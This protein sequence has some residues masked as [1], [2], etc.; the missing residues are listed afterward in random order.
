MKCIIYID[1]VIIFGKTFEEHLRNIEEVLDRMKR[2]RVLAKPSKC[3]FCQEE[4]TYLGH[5]VGNG[6][7]MMDDYNVQKIK[8]MD[9][10]GTL[11]E[12]RSFVCLSG[13][14]R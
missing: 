11:K 13:Y 10:P 8:K 14:Y 12:I 2:F 9:M 6:K 5:R 1:D 3:Q 7:L 4:V